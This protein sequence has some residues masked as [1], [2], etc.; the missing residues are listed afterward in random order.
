MKI[1]YLFS[2]KLELFRERIKENLE[3]YKNGKLRFVK[4]NDLVGSPKINVEDVKFDMSQNNPNETD[5]E[6]IKRFY[7][8]FKKLKDSQATEER[9]WA[10]LC[11][12][13]YFFDYL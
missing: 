3:H 1:Y 4:A 6:N 12:N 11:H 13:N 7:T 8:A 2:D 9:L 10:G 5:Y